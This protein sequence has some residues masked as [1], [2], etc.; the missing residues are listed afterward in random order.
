[1]LKSDAQRER[2]LVQI[3][4]FRKAL[5]K[6]EAQMSGKRLAAVRGSYQGMIRQLED[7]VHDYDRLK[8]GALVPPQVERLD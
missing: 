8:S 5:A 6:A 7:E 4:G 2:T 1:M 3:E